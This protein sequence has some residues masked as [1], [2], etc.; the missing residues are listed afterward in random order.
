MISIIIPSLDTENVKPL[1]AIIEKSIYPLPYEILIQTEKGY[2]NAV[3]NGLRKAKGDVIVI[4]DGDGSHNP[5]FFGKM[6]LMLKD[7]DIVIG[8]RYAVG[9]YSNDILLRKFVSR[10]FCKLTRT[11]LGLKE[12]SD[13][14]SGFIVLKRNV[15]KSVKLDFYGYKI[16]LSILMQA[17]G[18]FKI[19]ECPIIFEKS[20]IGDYVKP[21]NIKDGFQTLIFIAKLF[22][23]RLTKIKG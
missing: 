23:F 3:L 6:F 2:V 10:F 13:V 19:G 20:R 7:F 22:I 5:V 11:L 18:K 12:I 14:M 17:K 1:I 9:G 8:S 16:G 4:M 21:R 15:L